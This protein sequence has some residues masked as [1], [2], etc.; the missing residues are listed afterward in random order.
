MKAPRIRLGFQHVR[1]GPMIFRIEERREYV[2][3]RWS[4]DN[5]GRPEAGPEYLT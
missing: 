5:P 2:T 3:T 1:V 4:V